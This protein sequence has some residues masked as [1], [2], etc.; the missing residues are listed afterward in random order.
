M[1]SVVLETQLG[2]RLKTNLKT[3]K[4]KI[5]KLLSLQTILYECIKLCYVCT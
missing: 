4:H 3:K 2:I 5:N 1:R